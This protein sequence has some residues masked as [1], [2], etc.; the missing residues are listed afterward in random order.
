VRDQ[1]L[2]FADVYSPAPS[3]IRSGIAVIHADGS[4]IPREAREANNSNWLQKDLGKKGVIDF[5]DI[6]A[7][8]SKHS[9]SLLPASAASP[10]A[11]SVCNFSV[12]KWIRAGILVAAES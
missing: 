9:S 2:S 6:S 10:Q 5:Q 11:P 7:W 3:Q 4:E 12:T 8:P 1:S